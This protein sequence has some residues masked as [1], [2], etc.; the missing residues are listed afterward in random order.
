MLEGIHFLLTYKCTYECDHCFLYCSPSSSGTFTINQIQKV[1]LEAE[2]MG[3]IEWIFFEGGEP[4]MYYPLLIEAI[5]QSKKM[6]F[7]VGLVTNAYPVQSDEDAELWLSPLADMGIDLLSISNDLFHSG[8][9]D[10]SPAKIAFRKAEQLGLPVL[11][12]AIE[13][14]EQDSPDCERDEK[15]N[16]ITEGGPKYRGR[17]AD[18]LTEGVSLRKPEEMTECPFEELANPKRV[19]VDAFGNVHV[20]QGISMGNMWEVP[21]SRLVSEYKVSENPI[22]S[23]L[24]KGGPHELATITG[25]KIEAGYADECHYCFLTRRNLIEKYP[26]TLTPRQVYGLK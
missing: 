21:L 20:C 25:Q 4:L 26:E 12:I 7:K 9:P 19:H 5:K 16:P 17:A 6:G 18:L 23:P 13:K 22:C 1:L 10:N 8:D 3:S 15:G 11:S 2:K 24:H 14:P